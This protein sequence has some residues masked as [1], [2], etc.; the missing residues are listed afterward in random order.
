MLYDISR[1]VTSTT[2]V[3]PGDGPFQATPQYEIAHG[4]AVNLFRLSLSPH[5]GSHADAWYHHEADG[6]HPAEMPI[7]AYMGPCR[8]ITVQRRD[9]ALTA[10]DFPAG[11][12]DGVERLLV[13]SH[14]SATPDD[15]WPTE[16]PYV[17]PQLVGQL[18]AGGCRLIGLDSPSFDALT[19]TALP[20]HH[21]LYQHGLVNLE[22]L[23]LSGVPDGDYELIALPLKL[24]GVCGS[25]VRAVLRTR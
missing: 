24:G 7:D 21:A 9:G 22:C 10:D 16:F 11:S 3:W 18:A 1:T 15:Q 4:M 13:H 12:L 25:P 6:A 17:S 14:V 23:Q 19:S 2:A 5:T 8:V 20:G